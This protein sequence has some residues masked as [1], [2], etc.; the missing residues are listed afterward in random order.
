M[1]NC[2]ICQRT[3]ADETEFCSRDGTRLLEGTLHAEEQLAADLARRFRI[4]RR[5]GII[6]WDLRS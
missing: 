2:P 5:L 6:I 3:Y 1:K 4:I